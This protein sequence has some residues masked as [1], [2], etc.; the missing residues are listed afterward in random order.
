[1][2]NGSY[3]TR[4]EIPLKNKLFFDVGSSDD[5]RRELDAAVIAKGDDMSNIANADDA[6]CYAVSSIENSLSEANHLA[7]SAS[8]EKFFRAKRVR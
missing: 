2:L 8:V 3:G 6:S 1:L 5:H 4:L 7:R